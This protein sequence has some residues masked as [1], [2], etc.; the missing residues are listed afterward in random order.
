MNFGNSN[1]DLIE[2]YTLI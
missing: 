1:P 2:L